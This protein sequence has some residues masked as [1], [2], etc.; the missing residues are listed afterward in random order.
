MKKRSIQYLTVV[1]ACITMPF[2]TNISY[3]Q[4]VMGLNT[5]CHLKGAGKG[6]GG[7]Y[8][9]GETEGCSWVSNEDPMNEEA[10]RECD[11]PF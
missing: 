8:M 2:L 3:S 11:V 4:G 9:C 5:L 1:V 7:F 10:D 6:T